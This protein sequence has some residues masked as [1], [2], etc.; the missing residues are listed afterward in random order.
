MNGAP[1]GTRCVRPYLDPLPLMPLTA[2]HGPRPGMTSL[3]FLIPIARRSIFQSHHRANK[4]SQT[5][6][7][8]AARPYNACHDDDACTSARAHARSASGCDCA[9]AAPP[10]GGGG[11]GPPVIIAEQL[12]CRR[13]GNDIEARYAGRTQSAS[14]RRQ[15]RGAKRQSQRRRQSRGRVH[16]AQSGRLAGAGP[17]RHRTGRNPHRAAARRAGRPQDRDDLHRH[18]RWCRGAA[19]GSGNSH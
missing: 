11:E 15:A 17:R 14:R 19:N 6:S 12:S 5:Y 7:P 10:C 3:N 4:G 9:R 8:W 1:H 18:P 13:C 2:V 16:P